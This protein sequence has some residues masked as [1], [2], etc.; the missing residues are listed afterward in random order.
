MKILLKRIKNISSLLV[1][2]FAWGWSGCL[3]AETSVALVKS[4]KGNAFLVHQG[5]MEFL[6]EGALLRKGVEI[7]TEEKAQLSFTDYENRLY[8]LS[9]GGH[10]SLAPYGINLKNGFLWVQLLESEPAKKKLRIETVNAQISILEKG[11]AILSFDQ[12]LEKTQLMVITGSF[13]LKTLLEPLR[14]E[15]IRD[16]QFSFIQEGYRQGGPR[17]PTFIGFHS[18]QRALNLFGGIDPLS[19]MKKRNSSRLRAPASLRPQGLQGQKEKALF[20]KSLEHEQR[21]EI[22]ALYKRTKESLRKL[23]KEKFETKKAVKK[24]AKKRERQLA[25]LEKEGLSTST[26]EIKIHAYHGS[27]Q[28]VGTLEKF[29]ARQRKTPQQGRRPASLGKHQDLVKKEKESWEKEKQ[30]HQQELDALIEELEAI[31]LP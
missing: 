3:W 11:E 28:G 26:L 16:G 7:F 19:A 22:R 18:Y 17:R 1:L 20:Q 5:K 10:L 2:T 6:R 27:D 15:Q 4:V 23:L 13:R 9:G 30:R 24:K 29:L 25:S 21:R 8:H 14:K 12:D 31:P